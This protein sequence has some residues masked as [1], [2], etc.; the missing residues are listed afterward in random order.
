MF[1]LIYMRGRSVWDLQTRAAI[2]L[3]ESNDV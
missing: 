1:Q 2:L 3:L